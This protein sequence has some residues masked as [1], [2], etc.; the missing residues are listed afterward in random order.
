MNLTTVLG[1][2]A[3][4][5]ALGLVSASAS[6]TT[7]ISSGTI[8]TTV[9]DGN[10]DGITSML[11]VSG[12]GNI[13][14]SG[15]NVSVTLNISGGN[16]G[17][18]V[19]YLIFGSHTVTLLNRPGLAGDPSGLGYMDPGYNNVTLSDGSYAN[20]NS[21]GGSGGAQVSTGTYNPSGGSTT[22]QSYNGLNSD[23]SWVLFISDLSG[24]DGA[25]VS[26][27]NNWSLTITTVPEK[28]NEALAFFGIIVIG[29][30]AVRRWIVSRKNA[31]RS[32]SAGS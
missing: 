22:F 13:L 15:D 21:Y 28:E 19:A 27:L 26:V 10:S 30:I 4:G 20:I 18:L 5:L 2:A 25:N 8:N 9:P 16:N 14:S 12:L 29:G 23:G 3:C 6:L 32:E 17:D 7:T 31:L 1:G 24:G 11:N